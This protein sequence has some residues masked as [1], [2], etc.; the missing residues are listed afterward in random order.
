MSSAQR[1]SDSQQ[2]RRRHVEAATVF[3]FE[4]GGQTPLLLRRAEIAPVFLDNRQ[5][6]VPMHFL[7]G[8][9]PIVPMEGRPQR[10]MAGDDHAPRIEH[11]FRVQAS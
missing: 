5:L 1:T 8:F 6:D 10:R 11:R 9:R 4:Q 3:R 2:R 7:Y